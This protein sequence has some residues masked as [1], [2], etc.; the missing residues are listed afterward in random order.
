L[1]AR[2]DRTQR[3]WPRRHPPSEWRE[4]AEGIAEGAR[5]CTAARLASHLLRLRVDPYVTLELLKGWNLRCTPPLPE[6]D[7]VRVVDSICAK[8]L[9]RRSAK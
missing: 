2:P 4:L 1:A 3:Q 5:N 9:Q 7:I 6:S 8:E